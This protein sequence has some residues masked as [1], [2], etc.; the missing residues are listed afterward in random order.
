MSRGPAEG[1]VPHH[2]DVG[3]RGEPNLRDSLSRAVTIGYD[4]QSAVAEQQ[5]SSNQAVRLHVRGDMGNYILIASL[6]GIS[7]YDSDAGRSVWFIGANS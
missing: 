5:V 1:R 7:L 3:R 6:T 2:V 4:A